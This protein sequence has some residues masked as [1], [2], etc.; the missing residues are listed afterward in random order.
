MAQEQDRTEEINTVLLEALAIFS[1]LDEATDCFS[2]DDSRFCDDIHKNS[3]Y[4]LH[5]CF[6]AALERM[7]KARE[8]IDMENEE[9]GKA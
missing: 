6:V 1:F 7:E 5:L 4:G 3:G 9:G 2:N 8:L